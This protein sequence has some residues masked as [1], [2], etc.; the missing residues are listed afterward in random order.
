MKAFLVNRVGDFGFAL[1]VFL[2][3][4]TYGTLDF[5]DTT[6]AGVVHAGILGQ[7]MLHDPSLYAG[8]GRGHGDL[9]AADG[10]GLR[11]ERPVPLARLAARRHGRPHAG[12]RAD[13]RGHDGHGRRLPGGPLHAAVCGLGRRPARGGRD[14]RLHRPAGRPDRPDPDRPETHPG[15]FDHQPAR[16]H[17]SG[18]GRRARWRAFRPACSTW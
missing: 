8:G 18:L 7:T 5:H 16:L 2:L 6:V 10:G 9:P 13:P 17:V 4:I 15:L 12:Q 11:Q 14:R 3:W 1:G